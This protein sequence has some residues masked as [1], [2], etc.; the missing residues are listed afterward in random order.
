ML[1]HKVLTLPETENQPELWILVTT[2]NLTRSGDMR[3]LKPLSKHCCTVTSFC[4]C[5][6]EKSLVSDEGGVVIRGKT[7]NIGGM[8]KHNTI[9]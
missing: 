4:Q 2:V 7:I 1:S 9:R 5:H 8:V 3:K 6:K